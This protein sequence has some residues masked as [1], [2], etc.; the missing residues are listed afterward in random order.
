MA[1]RLCLRPHPLFN[2][3]RSIK[4]T[5]NNTLLN[6][7]DVA[8]DPSGVDRL[9]NVCFTLG[10]QF[11]IIHLGVVAVINW[12]PGLQHLTLYLVTSEV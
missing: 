2:E 12:T 1:D 7:V 3:G 5:L 9:V 8:V 11:G 6:A 10:I 4:F